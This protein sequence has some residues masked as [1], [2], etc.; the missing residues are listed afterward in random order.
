M[1]ANALYQL[2][3]HP[4]WF[5]KLQAEIDAVCG[6]RPPSWADIK[7]LPLCAAVFRETLRLVPPA[8]VIARLLTEPLELDGRTIPA[9]VEVCLP[10]FAVHTDRAAW[11]ADALEFDPA[12]WM[13]G[14]GSGTVSP[15]ERGAFMPFSDGPRSCL[16]R[17]FAEL[18]F[19]CAMACLLQKYTFRLPEGSAF[20]GE[21][22][23]TGFGY[24]P[25]DAKEG[26]VALNLVPVRR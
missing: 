5:A 26:K 1:M 4:E 25:W 2:A 6:G 19:T 11:G 7:R 13:G 20:K 24:R 18:E 14:D 23:F 12:R 17:H 15:A 10:A 16:G 9:G 8:A 22:I 21:Q 3:A